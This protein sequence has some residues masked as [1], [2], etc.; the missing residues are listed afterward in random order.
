MSPGEKRR[1]GSEGRSGAASGS[2]DTSKSTAATHDT[3]D[4]SEAESNLSDIDLS[5]LFEAAD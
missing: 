5:I 2:M 4:P 1:G 3:T